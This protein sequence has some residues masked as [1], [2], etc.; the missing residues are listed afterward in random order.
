MARFDVELERF[1]GAPDVPALAR[2]LGLD[3]ATARALASSAPR[4][5][6]RGLSEA[7]AERFFH[8]LRDLGARVRL[9]R[10]EALRRAPASDPAPS[11]LPLPDFDEPAF[12]EPASAA[13]PAS[14]VAAVGV[15]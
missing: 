9:H 14:P 5:V 3:E 15:P 12:D 8:A 4:V 6:K 7:E 1:E 11:D 2:A 10:V 13:R